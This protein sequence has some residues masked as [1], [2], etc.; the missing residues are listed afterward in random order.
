MA[1][2]LIQAVPWMVRIIYREIGL[3]GT[4]PLNASTTSGISI[5]QR[6]NMDSRPNVNLIPGK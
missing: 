3:R 6:Q 1:N 4:S 5:T 2:D